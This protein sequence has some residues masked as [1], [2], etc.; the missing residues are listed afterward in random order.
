MQ[1]H[2]PLIAAALAVLAVPLILLSGCGGR[3]SNAETVTSV[4]NGYRIARRAEAH[5]AERWI[6]RHAEGTNEF[7]IAEAIV[8]RNYITAAMQGTAFVAS[9]GATPSNFTD[10]FESGSVGTNAPILIHET[11]KGT[12]INNVPITDQGV[13]PLVEQIALLGKPVVLRFELP[14][15]APALLNQ[16]TLLARAG[17]PHIILVPEQAMP[18]ET[19]PDT[20]K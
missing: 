14:V 18:F 4:G 7:V 10:Y 19:V 12:T 1:T 3:N 17:V 13:G 8:E 5:A 6:F 2:R 16:F 20:K 11:R 15:Q 9:N